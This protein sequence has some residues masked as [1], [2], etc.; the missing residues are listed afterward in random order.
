MITQIDSKTMVDAKTMA[1]SLRTALID[2]NVSLSHSDCLEIVARQFGLADW[3]TLSAKLT[4]EQERSTR[5]QRP[6]TAQHLARLVDPSTSAAENASALPVTDA[7]A[8]AKKDEVQ[9]DETPAP[10]STCSFCGKSPPEVRIVLGGCG[11]WEGF[12]KRRNPAS[13]ERSNAFICNECIV[14]C[15]QIAKVHVNNNTESQAT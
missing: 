1:K 8:S 5:P 7:T 3:N 4:D 15:A 10:W 12:R 2:R 6:D 14:L 11:G 13:G 9:N